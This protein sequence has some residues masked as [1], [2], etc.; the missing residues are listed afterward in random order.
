ME[1]KRTCQQIK[2]TEGNGHQKYPSNWLHTFIRE[3]TGA[4]RQ[5]V[6]HIEN[7]MRED[8]FHSTL[9][10]QTYQQLAEAARE[11]Y[12]LLKHDRELYDPICSGRGRN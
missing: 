12:E 9:D 6:K 7:I 4:C 2:Q 10:W 3:I 11:A 8:I 5:D 1:P